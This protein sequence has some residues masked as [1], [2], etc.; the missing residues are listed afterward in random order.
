[1]DC[2]FTRPAT[3][4]CMLANMVAGSSEAFVADMNARA[5]TL[6]LAGTH[7]DDVTGYSPL[8]VSTA[9][10]QARLA[11]LLME[12]PLVRAIVDQ[13]ERDPAL[14]RSGVNSLRPSWVTTT[15]SA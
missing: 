9:L 8:S 7:Y 15:S 2:W 1:M 11:A 12:S 10:D 14:R 13:T 4:R 3:T 6:G 5:A